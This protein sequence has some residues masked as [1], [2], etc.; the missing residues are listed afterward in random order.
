MDPAFLT[1]VATALLFV[2]V[3]QIWRAPR[4]RVANVLNRTHAIHDGLD[5]GATGWRKIVTYLS[6]RFK[7]Y[8]PSSQLE[9]LREKL[10]WAGQPLGLSAEE[11]L[12]ARIGV[13]FGAALAAP[14][15]V[16]M[17]GLDVS[18]G[19]AMALAGVV[20]YLLPEKLVEYQVKERSRQIRIALPAFVHLLATALEAGLPMVEAVRRVAAEQKGP[21]GQPSL[22]AA[23]MLRT[24]QEMAAGKSSNA[25][26]QHLLRRTNCEELRDVV[27]AV[28]Q[29]QELGVGVAEQLRF[30]MRAVRTKKQQAAQER[31]QKASVQMKIPTIVLIVMPTLVILLGPAALGVLGAIMGG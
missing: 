11:F 14:A 21:S 13:V 27:G 15:L 12:F 1:F 9:E 4:Q 29:S 17:L 6:G 10:L 2:G 30:H 26:W 7:P 18:A 3:Y 24:V 5:D 28:I 31:A 22:L 25:A 16:G 19:G 23:E 8:L 20:G